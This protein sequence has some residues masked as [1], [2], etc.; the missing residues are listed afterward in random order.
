[1]GLAAALRK[2]KTY[3]IPSDIKHEAAED[4]AHMMFYASSFFGLFS[5]HPPIDER[6]KALD[7]FNQTADVKSAPFVKIG[8]AKVGA[9]EQK[10]FN[11]SVVAAAAMI[12]SIPSRAMVTSE[13]S[14][15]AQAIILGILLNHG[16]GGINMPFLRT[17]LKDGFAEGVLNELEKILPEIASLSRRQSF[18]MVERS[19]WA[20]ASMS[21]NQ[22]NDFICALEKVC[23]LDHH[24]ELFELAVV[25]LVKNQLRRHIGDIPLPERKTKLSNYIIELRILFSL[26]AKEGYKGADGMLKAY[27]LALSEFSLPLTEILNLDTNKQTTE[28]AKA[29]SRLAL[30][31]ADFRKRIIQIAERLVLSNQ[32]VNDEEFEI[33]RMLSLSFGIPMEFDSKLN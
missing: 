19:C 28:L 12:S 6:I 20:L 21:K 30:T 26:L 29:I 8:A 18:V 31:S 24:F 33:I 27:H 1:L 14:L 7:R 4:A 23:F 11:N 15:G 10:S 25:S 2:I 22:A 17:E 3:E 5:T 32:Q 9:V 16:Q 13:E